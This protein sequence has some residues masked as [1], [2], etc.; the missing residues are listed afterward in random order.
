MQG[1]YW[2]ALSLNGFIYSSILGYKP[3]IALE[4]L[5][6]GALASGLCGK[7]PTVSAVVTNDNIDQVKSVFQ[8]YDGDVVETCLNHKKAAVIDD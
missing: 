6:A 8:K 3:D 7:G 4:A 2:I 5:E 1:N